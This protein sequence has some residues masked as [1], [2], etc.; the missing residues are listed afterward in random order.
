MGSTG[1]LL[2]GFE[3]IELLSEEETQPKKR[4]NLEVEVF[5]EDDFLAIIN[6]PA[7]LVVSGNS[8]AT[9]N[10][11]LPQNLK[12]STLPDACSPRAVHRLDYPTSGLLLVGKTHAAVVALSKLFEKK[13]YR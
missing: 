8:F 7:G 6:K 2:H 3:T 5:Y 12:K 9:I 4:F 10:N 13:T 1:L 11:C